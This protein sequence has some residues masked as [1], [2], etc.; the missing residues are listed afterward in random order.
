MARLA[1]FWSVLIALSIFTVT[2]VA[3]APISPEPL[4]T[5]ELRWKKVLIP[6]AFSNSLLKANPAVR[7]DSDIQEAVRRSLDAWEAAANIE[8]QVTWTDKLSVSPAGNT[9]DGTSIVTIA[10]TTENLL[11]FGGDAVEI[12]ARTR[13]F[14]N[15]RGEISEADIVL[16]PYQQ[17]STDGSI[18]TFDFES[19]LTHELG[20]LLGLEHSTVPGSTMNEH[21]AKNGFY[22]LSSFS[23]RTLSEDDI[24]QI[25]AIYGAKDDEDCCGAID[26][27]LTLSNVK[28]AKNLKVWLEEA[29]TG[30]VSFGGRLNADGSFLLKGLQ[31]NKYRLYT[32]D[33]AGSFAGQFVGEVEVVKGRTTSFL[34]KIT[35]AAKEFDVQLTGF[36]GQLSTLAIPINGGK[37][38]VIFVGGKNLSPEDFK[39]DTTSPFFSVSSG[40]F[41]KYDYG[42]DLSVFSFEIKSL[43]ETPAGEY[44]FYLQNRDGKIEFLPATL[45]V[46]KFA[47][48]WSSLAFE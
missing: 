9:G 35:L 24:V 8:F 12:P 7:P 5:P 33:F 42:K 41:A 18:G 14:F 20:H 13:V 32:Q 48:P 1:K 38:Y 3:D 34:K 19:T 11:V 46:E 39:V 15:R 40:N 30:R 10:Q 25:R 44:T 22:Q 26:G 27:K 17:F 31:A 29:Q 6:V 43:P 23:P 37:S 47:N 21:Q 16:N 45:T 36:N 2:T 4:K 28:T